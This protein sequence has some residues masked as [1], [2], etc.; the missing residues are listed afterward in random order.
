MSEIKRL[1]N[2]LK[3]ANYTVSFVQSD[4]AALSDY[5]NNIES[6][7]D[8]LRAELDKL[9]EQKA[10]EICNGAKGG[11][12]GNENRIDGK[13]VCDYCSA[14]GSYLP[15]Q[16]DDK[17]ANN[18][19]LLKLGHRLTELLDEDKWNNIEPLLL[20]ISSQLQQ[21]PAGWKL[22]PIKEDVEMRSAGFS[23]CDVTVQ[24]VCE[25]WSAMLAAAPTPPSAASQNY[26]SLVDNGTQS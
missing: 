18:A 11:V 5:I 1:L 15:A 3:N 19:A 21:S 25:I 13:I 8:T 14:D 23:C 4:R 10:C 26:K 9:K 6:E 16:Q 17:P 2:Y 20:E 22:V 12:R 7:R 24:K